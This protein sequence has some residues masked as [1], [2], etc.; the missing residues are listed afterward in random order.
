MFNKGTGGFYEPVTEADR[1]AE[2]AMRSAIAREYA[3]DGVI[4]EEFGETRV[5]T[6]VQAHHEKPM[7]EWLVLLF[8]SVKAFAGGAPQEDDMTAVVVKR[9]A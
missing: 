8:E 9:K 4:G 5:Q 1:R 7:A 6:L 3:Q 2:Q